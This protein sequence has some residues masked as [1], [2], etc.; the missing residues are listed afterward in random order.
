M[1]DVTW[2]VIRTDRLKSPRR[3]TKMAIACIE[4][5]WIG[6]KSRAIKPDASTIPRRAWQICI[7]APGIAVVRNRRL[8]GE[9]IVKVTF[10]ESG[11]SDS[12]TF[13]DGYI[14]LATYMVYSCFSPPAAGN[15]PPPQRRQ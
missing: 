8:G 2:R 4:N 14:D 5:I 10:F 3:I 11:N 13:D 9:G 12:V 6:F 15:D 7:G 1:P